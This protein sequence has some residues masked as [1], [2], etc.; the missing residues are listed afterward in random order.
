LVAAISDEER[1]SYSEAI[2]RLA[3]RNAPSPSGITS[4]A[5]IGELMDRTRRIRLKRNELFG[6]PLFRDPSFDML[7]ELFAVHQRGEEISVTSLC[8][9]SGVPATTALRH[10]GQ[11]E[12]HGLIMRDGDERDQRRSHVWPTAKAIAGIEAI[13]DRWRAVWSHATE[14]MDNLAEE[15]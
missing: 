11:L 8:Y 6:A 7:L 4:H 5:V 10:L 1:C 9:A 13:F 2:E 3:E 12:K 14:Q 15:P